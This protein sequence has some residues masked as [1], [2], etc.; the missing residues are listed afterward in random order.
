MLKKTILSDSEID[1]RIRDVRSVKT[2]V[3]INSKDNGPIS[4]QE[5]VLRQK[6]YDFMFG[7][8]GFE[9]IPL[10]M[11]KLDAEKKEYSLK[12]DAKVHE[13][14]NFITLPFYWGSFEPEQGKPF[15]EGLQKA[16]QWHI[17]RG[18][19]VKGH[20]LC[21][22]SVN[23][24]WLL[25]YTN[26]EILELQ[27]GRIIREM[28]DFKGLIEIWDVVNEAVIMPIFDKY[29]NAM[30]RLCLEMGRF[31]L[32]EEMFNQAREANPGAV[33]LL[34]DFNLTEAFEILIE[35]CLER[36]IPIDAIG[37]QTHMHQGY[38]GRAQILDILDR[39]SRYNLPL[40]MTEISLVSG[41][42]MPPEIV[43]LNDYQ[44]DDWPST[45]EGEE[46][47]AREL[48]DLFKILMACPQV[49]AITLWGF[50]DKGWLN[51]P[52][53]LLRE[54]LSEKPSFKALE[55]LIKGDWW[56]A[57]KKLVTDEKGKVVF[58]GFPGEYE[59]VCRG[60]KQSFHVNKQ[61][62]SV[63]LVV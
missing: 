2:E 6:S 3:K 26:Q 9:T 51:A 53:G 31:P 29:D 35:G 52:I 1:Q 34:N 30:T 50:L 55:N 13:L 46:R 39:F 32:L 42:L 45:V 36:G 62:D 63:V 61:V 57:E 20:P 59:V 54:D 37:L 19:K 17:D 24:E 43:D 11:N 58:Q 56:V 44:I 40:H 18:C 21:W 25:S 48:S 7:N 28:H 8:T 16:A 12:R 49:E 4:R 60:L 5:I 41:H 47:Q 14:F 33:L 10:A 15:T 38:R 22:H 27:K 23:N